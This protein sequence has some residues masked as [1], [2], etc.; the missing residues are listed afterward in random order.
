MSAGAGLRRA[1]KGA[2][3][4]EVRK[5]RK[6][7]LLFEAVRLDLDN[8]AAVAAWCGGEIDG[9]VVLVPTRQGQRPALP[10]MWVTLGSWGEFYPVDDDVLSAVGEDAPAGQS[11]R[12]RHAGEDHQPPSL[13]DA[14]RA[15]LETAREGRS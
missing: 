13:A 12:I 9:D 11:F 14:L 2:G 8:T 10:G 7:A 6:R 3:R 4:V 5:M 15:S 1:S